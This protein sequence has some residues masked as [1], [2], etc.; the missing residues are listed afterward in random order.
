[1]QRLLLANVLLVCAAL[2]QPVISGSAVYYKTHNSVCVYAVSDIEVTRMWLTYDLVS[3]PTSYQPE[4]ISRIYPGSGAGNYY[5]MACVTNLEPS[6]PY[7]VRLWASVGA[8]T[9]GSGTI[10]SITTDATPVDQFGEPVP[11]AVADTLPALPTTWDYYCDIETA[12]NCNNS[13]NAD[14]V[15]GGIQSC[16]DK[17]VTRVSG[18]TW[19]RLPDGSYDCK[20]TGSAY[21]LRGRTAGTGLIYIAPASTLVPEG[22]RMT[23]AFPI[24]AIPGISATHNSANDGGAFAGSTNASNYRISGLRI[25]NEYDP[26]GTGVTNY[27]TVVSNVAGLITLDGA[28]GM[29][30]GDIGQFVDLTTGQHVTNALLTVNSSTSVTVTN[31]TEATGTIAA[32]W[33]LVLGERPYTTSSGAVKFECIICLDNSRNTT[34]II[35]DRNYV[36]RR[37]WP[38]AFKRA[39]RAGTSDNYFHNNS[40]IDFADWAGIHPVSLARYGYATQMV[41]LN[42]TGANRISVINNRFY[43]GPGISLFT[44]GGG[45]VATAN[46]R[47]YK[48]N[49]IGWNPIYHDKSVN[50]DHFAYECRQPYEEKNGRRVALIGNIF[51]T[52]WGCGDTGGTAVAILLTPRAADSNISTGP[53]NAIT[54]F[55]AAYNTIRNGPGVVTA[56]AYDGDGFVPNTEPFKRFWFVHNLMYNID[57]LYWQRASA[58]SVRGDWFYLKQVL[59]AKVDH[60]TAYLNVGSA[61]G[62]LYGDAQRGSGLLWTNNLLTY[63]NTAAVQW[64]AATFPPVPAETTSGTARTLIES[65]WKSVPGNITT[66]MIKGNVFVPTV[67]STSANPNYGLTGITN[68]STEWGTSDGKN[69]IASGATGT[70]RLDYVGWAARSAFNLRLAKGSPVNSAAKLSTDGKNIGVDMNQLEIE[71]GDVKNAHAINVGTT[72]ATVSYF[73][74]DSF[75]CTVEYSTSSTW[76]TGTRVSD[77]G[78]AKRKRNVAIGSGGGN[79]VTGTPQSDLTPATLYYYRVLCAVEQPSGSFRTQ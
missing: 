71:R 40:F 2:A 54:D 5:P 77:G 46:D 60:N 27:V 73:A 79:D 47:L 28:H 35:F 56:V 10:H 25:T 59:D 69:A 67:T 4:T 37:G 76:G 53:S 55:K 31:Q 14:Q 74:P 62:L 57:G 7:Y 51:D 65:A 16:I 26:T 8:G 22:V 45:G 68:G 49:F 39:I 36:Y 43:G 1:M 58:G 17:A 13:L 11:P 66:A 12:N 52:F 61:A 63:G 29:S 21:M 42:T 18:T 75:A 34:N 64:N 20:P 3:P 48:R 50:W 23:D 78:G 24:A 70:A 33:K 32:G 15:H 44:E 9:A 38:T 30:T 72:S 19:V 6:T 41:Y